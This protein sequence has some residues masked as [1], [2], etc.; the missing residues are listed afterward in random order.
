MRAGQS[1][2]RLRENG[3]GAHAPLAERCL[4]ES[5]RLRSNSHFHKHTLRTNFYSALFKARGIKICARSRRG[6]FAREILT[7]WPL[8]ASPSATT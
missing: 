6:L 4:I 2:A 1:F 5:R 3:Y 8:A 7:A